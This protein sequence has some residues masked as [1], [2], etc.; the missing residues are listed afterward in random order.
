INCN[1]LKYAVEKVADRIREKQENHRMKQ[2]YHNLSQPGSQRIG[3]PAGD[4][5]EY[6][7]VGKIVRCQGEGNYT[8]IWF[9][10][11]KHLL[12]AKTLVEFEDLLQEFGFV[13]AHKTHLVNLKHV[14]AFL[15]SGSLL[16]LKNGEQIPV[17]RRRKE[18]VIEQLRKI[19]Q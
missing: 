4:R 15:K 8:H 9:D 7:D 11:D 3:L 18:K 17:S 5:I 2:L 19:N 6:S 14:A 16:K 12:A 13:R 1:D 10:D